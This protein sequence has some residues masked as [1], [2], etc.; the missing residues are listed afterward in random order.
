MPRRTL[1]DATLAIVAAALAVITAINAEWI[2]WLTGLDPDGGSGTLEWAIVGVFA[3]GAV[4]A[5][6]QARRDLRRWRAGGLGQ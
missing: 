2:E 4:V 1:A 3:L 6:A 5:G